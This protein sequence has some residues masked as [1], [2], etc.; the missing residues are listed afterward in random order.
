MY[1]IYREITALS[2]DI[3]QCHVTP[4]DTLKPH[5]LG[6][7]AILRAKKKKKVQKATIL[8]YFIGRILT[9]MGFYGIH[10]GCKTQKHF[11]SPSPSLSVSKLRNC[12]G[13]LT[14][15]P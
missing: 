3:N 14:F 15:T 10:L 12:W 7:V 6:D 13:C 1:S 2:R 11:S 4:Q 5:K 8:N 9:E